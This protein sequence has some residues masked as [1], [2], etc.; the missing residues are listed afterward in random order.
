MLVVHYSLLASVGEYLTLLRAPS[1]QDFRHFVPPRA[2][3]ELVL[4]VCVLA[5]LGAE[6]HARHDELL[7]VAK[8]LAWV[9]CSGVWRARWRLTRIACSKCPPGQ[10]FAAHLAFLRVNRR[11]TDDDS[12][13]ECQVATCG[14]SIS[15]AKGSSGKDISI[16]NHAAQL[17]K[18]LR[19]VA[20]KRLLPQRVWYLAAAATLLVELR[21]NSELD[22]LHATDLL[23]ACFAAIVAV[24]GTVSLVGCAPAREAAGVC[25]A[26]ADMALGQLPAARALAQRVQ[27][28]THHSLAAQP[29]VPEL[30]VVLVSVGTRGDVQPFVGLALQFQ[31]RGHSVVLCATSKFR[32][33]VESHGVAFADCGMNDIPHNEDWHAA[34]TLGEVSDPLLALRAGTRAVWSQR[35]LCIAWLSQMMKACQGSYHEY[36]TMCKG[37]LRAARGEACGGRQADVLIGSL[38]T[39]SYLMDVGESLGVPVWAVKVGRC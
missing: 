11:G 10:A 2:W 21:R 5:A 29:P 12:V 8:V 4:C 3:V 22:T 32:S 20:H 14:M 23:A 18:E 37:F 28:R 13:I 17:V 39:M 34:K 15:S 36:P 33:F 7:V 38:T 6:L 9:R 24:V 35:R 1:R 26:D 27:Q 25:V 19:W 31:R 16:T 30:H